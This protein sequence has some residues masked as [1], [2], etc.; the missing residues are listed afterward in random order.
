MIYV[1]KSLSVLDGDLADIS[2]KEKQTFDANNYL[3]NYL[4][5]KYLPI[6]SYL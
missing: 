3:N 4:L 1:R 6:H 5:Y 2:Q